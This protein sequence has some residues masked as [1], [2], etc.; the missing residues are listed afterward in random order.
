MLLYFLA[1]FALGLIVYAIYLLA[2]VL[3]WPPHATVFAM[4]TSEAQEK[5]FLTILF[6]RY[7][8]EV[9]L[10]LA[11]LIFPLSFAIAGFFIARRKKLAWL[12]R[13]RNLVA[14]YFLGALAW[15]VSQSAFRGFLPIYDDLTT[16][17]RYVYLE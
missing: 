5:K 12:E 8:A 3:A 10:G 6:H 11:G 17:L 7:Q 14:L 13:R 15:P 16:A 4:P 9:W 2:L 1:G